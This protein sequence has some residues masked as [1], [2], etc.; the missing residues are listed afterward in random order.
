MT[1]MVPLLGIATI[2]ATAVLFSKNHRAINWRLVTIG[3]GLQIL[4]ALL[5][6]RTSRV[7]VA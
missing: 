2:L 4:V 6:F 3:L 5:V 1:R 7:L